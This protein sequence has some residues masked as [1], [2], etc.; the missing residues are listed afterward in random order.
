MS[1]VEN[2]VIFV[3]IAKLVHAPELQYDRVM[4]LPDRQY[5]ITNNC[6]MHPRCFWLA[7]VIFDN[8]R[9]EYVTHLI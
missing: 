2:S 8:G 7:A 1:F 3:G 6:L 4:S 5:L 9:A